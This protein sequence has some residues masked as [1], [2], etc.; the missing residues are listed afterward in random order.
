MARQKVQKDFLVKLIILRCNIFSI[1]ITTLS[2]PPSCARDIKY[3]VIRSHINYSLQG[4]IFEPNG[5]YLV[6]TIM[7]I[8]VK[9][10]K[11]CIFISSSC[12]SLPGMSS[13]IAL[14][15]HTAMF[16][17]IQCS[18]DFPLPFIAL[19]AFPLLEFTITQTAPLDGTHLVAVRGLIH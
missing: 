19:L 5:V 1:I 15:S 16:L 6:V 17:N 8:I 9:Q 2:R 14:I 12:C 3:L 4:Y 7:H 11:P 18:S 10:C 13:I